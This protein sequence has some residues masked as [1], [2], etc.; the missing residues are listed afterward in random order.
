MKIWLTL[1]AL[2]VLFM[3]GLFHLFALMHLYPL[4]ITSPLL[5]AAIFLT[6]SAASYKKTFKGFH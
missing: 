6:V 5:F 2:A 1:A 4:Y 3:L